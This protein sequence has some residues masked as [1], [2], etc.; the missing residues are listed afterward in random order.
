MNG[1]LPVLTVIVIGAIVLV[2]VVYLLGIIIALWSAQRS[3]ARLVGGLT[4]VRDQTVPLGPRL[5]AI[6]EG[7]SALL[8]ALVATDGN[9][10]AI[11]TV[12]AAQQQAA[13]QHPA[14]GRAE[15]GA[16]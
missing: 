3:L 16:T 13:Q 9:L 15:Q 10:K 6:N 2:L 12:A 8:D 14:S 4:V 1:F 5:V 11:L 7:L